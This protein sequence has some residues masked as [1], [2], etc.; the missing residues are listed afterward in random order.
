[1][2]RRVLGRGY[3]TAGSGSLLTSK[4]SGRKLNRGAILERSLIDGGT[5]ET[6]LW[7]ASRR[8]RSFS[9]GLADL[10]CCAWLVMA[11][12]SG[13]E[14]DQPGAQRELGR[15]YESRPAL[16]K[17]PRSS[18]FVVFCFSCRG[19]RGRTSLVSALRSFFTGSAPSWLHRGRREAG[20]ALSARA[21][22]SNA[23]VRI[24]IPPKGFGRP[25][26]A[27]EAQRRTPRRSRRRSFS[28]K[29]PCFSG[30]ASHRA[31]FPA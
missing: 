8:R 4:I 31:V 19:F 15:A 24:S 26:S 16:A 27:A 14:E 21:A 5:N 25:R 11:C 1:M 22:A 13:P 23:S 28:L 3:H 29:P 7:R 12:R 20:S 2:S 30:C 18:Y 10:R 17:R 6:P 9:A